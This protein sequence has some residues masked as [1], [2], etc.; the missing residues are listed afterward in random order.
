MISRRFLPLVLLVIISISCFCS[1]AKEGY[2]IKVNI[3][4]LK[5]TTS[6]LAYYYGNNQ[7]IKDTAYVDSK[8][9]FEFKGDSTLGKGMYMIVLPGQQYFDIIIDNDQFFE[10]NSE[11][12]D[13]SG[14]LTFKGSAENSSFYEYLRTLKPF[15]D[16]IS[17]LRKI[18]NELELGTE[19]RESVLKQIKDIEDKVHSLQQDF[20]KQNPNGLFSAVLKAQQI[21]PVPEPP[22]KADG[23]PDRELLYYLFLDEYWKNVDLKDERLLRTPIFHQKLNQFFSSVAIQIPDSII[24]AADRLIN[25]TRGNDEIFKYVVWFVMNLSERSNI[26]GMDALFVHMAEKYYMSGDA[27]WVSEEQLDRISKRAI[28]QKPLLIGAVAP[29]ITVFT[30]ERKTISLHEIESKYLVLYFWDSDCSHCKK[31]T[32]KL[33]DVYNKMNNNELKV[34]AVNTEASR[35]DW[36]N[37]VEKNNLNWINVHDPVNTSGFREKYDLFA[38]PIIYV[39]DKDKKIIAKKINPEQLEELISHYERMNK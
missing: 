11:L 20:I 32:P 26:M 31:V 37:Y 6:I 34:F 21:V 1:F 30:P 2:H 28:A 3:N 23:T 22:M 19:R 38:V 16:N 9:F 14:K 10:I 8:G 29:D 5:D 39:L 35:E 13:I 7:Y 36:L 33:K 4:G 25:K 12:K 24:T 15:S 27:F 17:E 18:M